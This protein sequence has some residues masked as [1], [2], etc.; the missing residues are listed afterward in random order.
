MDDFPVF[1]NF[2]STQCGLTVNRT[3]YETV[4]FVNS[5][6]TLIDT[7]DMD[8]DDFVKITHTTNSARPENGKITIPKSA[9]FALKTLRFELED[10][11]RCGALPVLATIQSLD[12]V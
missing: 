9:I 10:M 8:I 7:S 4:G 12:T 2:L 6:T 1:E 5:F 11:V 3:R